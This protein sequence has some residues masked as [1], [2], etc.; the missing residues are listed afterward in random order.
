[1]NK[2]KEDENAKPGEVAAIGLY[3]DMKGVFVEGNVSNGGPN[4]YVEGK[5]EDLVARGNISTAIPMDLKFN[6]E[7]K[8]LMLEQF[9][10]RYRP[11]PAFG[12]Q[13]WLI[14]VI[15]GLIPGLIGGLAVAYIAFRMGWT[16]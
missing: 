5:V 12:W 13:A 15:G 8:P 6:P 11:D 3:G 4:L 1:M 2:G 9:V 10:P 16:H 7:S 14:P